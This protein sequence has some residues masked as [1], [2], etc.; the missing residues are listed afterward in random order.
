LGKW[1]ER[2]FSF[3]L[4]QVLEQHYDNG[5]GEIFRSKVSHM[6]FKALNPEDKNNF[7]MSKIVDK[8]TDQEYRDLGSLPIK[9][10]D[11]QLKSVINELSYEP[12][13]KLAVLTFPQYFDKH[14]LL[15]D[16]IQK[17]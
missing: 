12:Y 6:I 14:K 1:E 10:T 13:G 4:N 15:D 17:I 3:V 7:L 9:I 2:H 11:M 5:I 8:V 16:L